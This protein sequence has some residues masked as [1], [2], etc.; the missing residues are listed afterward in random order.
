MPHYSR[1]CHTAQAFRVSVNVLWS[2]L[3][4]G[5]GSG[6]TNV[7][8][9]PQVVGGGRYRT[10]VVH[11]GMSASTCSK[12]IPCHRGLNITPNSDTTWS[13]AASLSDHGHSLAG[14]EYTTERC[15]SSTAASNRPCSRSLWGVAI[16]LSSSVMPHDGLFTRH[17]PLTFAIKADRS[18]GGTACL[19]GHPGHRSC[20]SCS[21]NPI[22]L[23]KC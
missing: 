23:A 20:P 19:M 2:S 9:A 12:A 21:C 16:R 18:H 10:C 4:W 5:W 7:N 6:R 8:A 22:A 17:T 13:T 1:R 15:C 3:R 14:Y 11:S